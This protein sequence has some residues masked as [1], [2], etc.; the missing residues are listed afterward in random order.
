MNDPN[1]RFMTSL[2]S[3]PGKS[4]GRRSSLTVS[5]WHDPETLKRPPALSSS[6]RKHSSPA[7]TMPSANAH[8]NNPSIH[9]SESVESAAVHSESK[10]DRRAPAAAAAGLWEPPVSCRRQVIHTPSA[11]DYHHFFPIELTGRDYFHRVL[12]LLARG[13]EQMA[14]PVPVLP[15]GKGLHPL[16]LE[17]FV[18]LLVASA[19]DYPLAALSDKVAALPATEEV[20]QVLQ[21]ILECKSALFAHPSG[22]GSSRLP[23]LSA[24]FSTAARL[25]SLLPPPHDPHPQGHPHPH[26]HHMQYHRHGPHP[27]HML[28]LL[29]AQELTCLQQ[30]LGVHAAF[31]AQR[32][33][34]LGW[35]WDPCDGSGTT[36]VGGPASGSSEQQWTAAFVRYEALLAALGP[37]YI[38]GPQARAQVLLLGRLL[39]L[40][41]ELQSAS[42]AA[43]ENSDY[44]E[45]ARLQDLAQCMDS[46]VT[47][48]QRLLLDRLHG[49]LFELTGLLAELEHFIRS[50]RAARQFDHAG[51]TETALMHLA[52]LK[53]DLSADLCPVPVLSVPLLQQRMLREGTGFVDSD[54]LFACEA[55]GSSVASLLI[56]AASA[57]LLSA[58]EHWPGLTALRTSVF[59]QV[60]ASA[61]A[62]GQQQQQQQQLVQEQEQMLLLGYD[63]SFPSEDHAQGYGYDASYAQGQG[64]GCGY[65]GSP[66]LRTQPLTLGS[67]YQGEL[68]S[69][70]SSAPAA[71]GLSRGP[72][73]LDGFS[74]QVLDMLR[75]FDSL[76]GQLDQLLTPAALAHSALLCRLL[77]VSNDL[78]SLM[79]I[80]D[81]S[82]SLHPLGG[83]GAYSR[84]SDRLRALV[85]AVEGAVDAD[86]AE[87]DG[88]ALLLAGRRRGDGIAQL[89]QRIRPGLRELLKLKA[90]AR[91]YR[92]FTAAAA[93]ESMLAGLESRIKAADE[94]I[95]PFSMLDADNDHVFDHSLDINERLA[96]EGT[97]FIT[98]DYVFSYACGPR[99]HSIGSLAIIAGAGAVLRF[100]KTNWP[101][102]TCLGNDIDASTRRRS[103][104]T[105]ASATSSGVNFHD[106]NALRA[107]GFEPNTLRVAGFSTVDILT[108]GYTAEQLKVAG[109]DAAAIQSAAGLSA[110]HTLF[111]GSAI[112]GSASGAAATSGHTLE[113]MAGL[114]HDM[115]Q[116]TEG[117]TWRHAAHWQELEGLIDLAANGYTRNGE[118]MSLLTFHGKLRALFL[119]LQGVQV[120][121]ASF[122]LQKLILPQNNLVGMMPASLGSITTLQ[123][124][125]LSNN[126]LCGCIPASIGLLVHLQSLV[127]DRN[128]LQGEI[129]RTLKHLQQLTVLRLEHNQLEGC[130]PPALGSL[131][132]LKRLDLSHNRLSGGLPL[133]LG[134]SGQMQLQEVLLNNNDLCGEIPSTWMQL[135]QLIHLDLHSNK[136]NGQLPSFSQL[137]KLT[138]LNLQDN[139]GLAINRQQLQKS[140][141]KCRIKL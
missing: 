49:L 97:G 26:P 128:Q 85:A 8:R 86:E 7:F 9:S 45:A 37:L 111:L 64:Y 134:A 39:A 40:E 6:V 127:L 115:F 102:L 83:A 19:P 89:I 66:S 33:Q 46:S 76:R 57:E 104:T 95:T 61:S 131:T 78:R 90:V 42:Q 117:S 10:A 103:V 130:L 4:P 18:H 5:N 98:A 87:A 25:L 79:D 17:E 84:E 91:S 93:L 126:Q 55:Q 2:R 123:H 100:I 13:F 43:A 60:S 65:G 56:Q 14:V 21:G 74:A 132:K 68:S 107:M 31:Q 109:F 135:S 41:Q 94:S 101:Q 112:N 36:G 1:V 88:E 110:D 44:D 122:D 80:A 114:L 22:W 63:S 133:R 137:T 113:V 51:M 11:G 118:K 50:K 71:A 52:S 141:P 47:A 138:G 75:A 20:E 27:H 34:A 108:A 105:S 59:S 16:L 23:D 53:R 77:G 129:P 69:R 124:L 119:K 35:R 121:R 62:A 12:A 3:S 82:S 29:L 73:A 125:V 48:E 72:A 28:L 99:G 38:S 96:R 30:Q 106:A 24:L 136:L 140:L 58:V 54:F 70:S 92:D 120:D 67:S 139:A 32:M 15:A 81:S 116:S